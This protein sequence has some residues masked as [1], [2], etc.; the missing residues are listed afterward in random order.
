MERRFIKELSAE[1]IEKAKAKRKKNGYT[2]QKRHTT[3]N[4]KKNRI[5][6]RYLR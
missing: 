6:T 1:G 2:R 4:Q 3:K 5:E